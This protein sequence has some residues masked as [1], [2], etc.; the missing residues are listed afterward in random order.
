MKSRKLKTNK[1]KTTRQQQSRRGAG[2]LVY[3]SI[4]PIHGCAPLQG[5]QGCQNAP[6]TGAITGYFKVF[7]TCN[8]GN[9]YLY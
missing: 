5:M 4:W 3:S 1:G 6:A 9:T 2:G 8:L 7:V